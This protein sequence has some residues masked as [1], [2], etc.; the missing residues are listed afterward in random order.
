MS[1]KMHYIIMNTIRSG[2]ISVDRRFC[3]VTGRLLAEDC[4]L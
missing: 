4:M 1:T 3:A 2:C